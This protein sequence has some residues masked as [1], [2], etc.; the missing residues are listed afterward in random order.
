MKASGQW[1]R[2]AVLWGATGAITA[3]MIVAGSSAEAAHSTPQAGTNQSRAVLDAN[4]VGY[5]APKGI[6]KPFT[7]CPL[8][9]PLMQESVGGS[10]TGCVA[11]DVSTGEIKIGNITTK[12][13][14]TAKVK[15]P[16]SV[17]FGIWDPANATPSQWT[18]GVLAPPVGGLSAQLVSIPQRV[19][20]GL[21]KALGCPSKV[22]TIRRL[23]SEAAHR[24]G[25]Y[26]RVYAAAESAGPITNFDLTTWTQPLEFHLINPLLGA[27]CSIGSD[28]NPVL[29]NPSLTGSSLVEEMDPHPRYHPDTAV[30]EIKGATATDTTFTAPGVT[31]CG[32]GGS[33][34][35]AVDEAIDT[36]V[37]LPTVS[38]SDSLTLNGTFYLAAC[39]A[40]QNMANILLSA[41]RASARSKGTAIALP[42]SLASLRT[43]HFGIKLRH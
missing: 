17:Q 9:N 41:F 8:Q 14:G 13:V 22:P 15:Y 19:P 37:G 4:G 27:S 16:V 28:D 30:L 2:R 33:A 5:P 21:L 12:V 3:A 6:Y 1:V 29:V 10:A 43:G 23:C 32:P 26:L 18:G 25:K 20:G 11:G 35:I 42:I 38:G 31:G 24:G 39:Y 36:A 34:N 7:D 40:P